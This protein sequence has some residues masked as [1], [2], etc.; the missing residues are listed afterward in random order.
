MRV[1]PFYLRRPSTDTVSFVDPPAATL[2]KVVRMFATF[3][4]LFQQLSVT[5]FDEDLL[6][7]MTV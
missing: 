3:S 1:A 2:I 4:N 7:E 5:C 6:R